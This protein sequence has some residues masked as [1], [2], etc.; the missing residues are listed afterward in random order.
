MKEKQHSAS[1]DRWFTSQDNTVALPLLG[2]TE[3]SN[4]HRASVFVRLSLS[5]TE[6]FCCV[7]RMVDNMRS[8]R[9]SI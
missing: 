6:M 4:I 9:K 8:L 7:V 1:N 2:F 5:N 3:A